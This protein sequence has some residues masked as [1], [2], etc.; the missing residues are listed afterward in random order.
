MDA[1]RAAGWCL[2]WMLSDPPWQEMGFKARP[3]Y[4]VLMRLFKSRDRLRFENSLKQ[5]ILAT[6]TAACA[7]AGFV[8]QDDIPE[9]IALYAAHPMIFRPL[10]FAS[11]AEAYRV[12]DSIVANYAELPI[13]S[14]P[15]LIDTRIPRAV[16]GTG[17]VARIVEHAGI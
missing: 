13:S 10:G 2:E 11:G 7:K 8:M 5:E 1:R 9:M 4:G 17:L 16:C 3:R 12:L 15:L 14:W 6:I